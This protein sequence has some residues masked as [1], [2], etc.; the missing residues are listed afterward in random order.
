MIPNLRISGF[1][2]TKVM[3]KRDSN[4]A[5]TGDKRGLCIS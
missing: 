3:K 4:K 5:L 2:S 1:V